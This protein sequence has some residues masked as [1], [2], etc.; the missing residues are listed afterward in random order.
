MPP[1]LRPDVD[2]LPAF[3]LRDLKDLGLDRRWLAAAVA[4]GDVVEVV[5]GAYVPAVRLG[6]PLAVA[7]AAALV[8]PPHVVACRGLAAMIHG[9]DPRGPGRD[10]SPLG[11]Q[12]LVP[13]ANRTPR[14][15]GV[16]IFEAPLPDGDVMDVGGVLVTTPERTALDCARYLSPPMALAVLD[17]M[18]RQGLVDREVLLLRIEEFRG[19]RGVGQAR[20]LIVH[21]EPDTESYGESWLRLRVVDAGFPRPEPQIWV[22]EPRPGADRLDMGWPQVRKGVEYDGEEFHGPE[23]ESADELRRLRLEQDFGWRF[24]SARKGAVLGPSMRL[25]AEIGELLGLAPRIRRR[26]W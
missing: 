6:D 5:R 25:E 8:L 11:V 23:Q 24:L 3:A 17:R 13:A 1:R 19:D 16:S 2:V 7:R 14:W 26:A 9:V 15:R 21:I 18:A 20:Y 10:D 4:T 12:G 22:P